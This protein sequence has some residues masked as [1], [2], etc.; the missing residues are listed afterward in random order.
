MF[1]CV[2]CVCVCVV[3]VCVQ[4]VSEEVWLRCVG[5]VD[6]PLAAGSKGRGGGVEGG[7]GGPD[8]AS[9]GRG[10]VRLTSVHERAAGCHPGGSRWRVVGTAAIKCRPS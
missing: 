6:G 9:G 3:C 8:P 7:G 5:G 2:G 1:V 10:A 4:V